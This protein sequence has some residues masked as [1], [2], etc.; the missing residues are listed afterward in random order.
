[1]GRPEQFSTAATSSATLI[2]RRVHS[3]NSHRH[4][5]TGARGV[6]ARDEHSQ[7]AHRRPQPSLPRRDRC[8]ADAR[9]LAKC[10]CVFV[11]VD[12]SS[13]TTTSGGIRKA[14]RCSAWPFSHALRSRRGRGG[15][16]GGDEFV[17]LLP[18]ARRRLATR[19]R[20]VR[21]E[22]LERAPVPFS[23]GWATREPGETL[24][25]IIDRADR[26]LMAVRV[27]KRQTDPRQQSAIRREP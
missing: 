5:G 4:H 18:R 17:I 8:R 20:P 15:R 2:R 13:G 1:M 21:I 11:D 24:M 9:S 25:Q 19:R 14:T 6:A 27:I 12:T 16:I 3:R 7:R 22:A 23:L 26:A 10:G